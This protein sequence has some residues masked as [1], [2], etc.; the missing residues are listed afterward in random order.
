MAT[1]TTTDP[2]CGMTVQ[3]SPAA[4]RAIH[5]GQDYVFCSTACQDRFT[6]DP[7]RYARGGGDTGA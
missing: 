6:T 4:P 5:A 1:T 7:D 3:D 2:V